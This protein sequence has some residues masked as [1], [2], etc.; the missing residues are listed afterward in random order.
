[1]NGSFSR[2]TVILMAAILAQ[3][4]TVARASQVQ[5]LVRIKGHE[6]NVLMGLGIVIGLNGT[7][8]NGR[9]SLSVARPYAEL[10]KSQG[11]AVMS[12]EELERA[13]SYAI[14][15]V[16]MEVPATGVRE[17]DRLDIFVETLYNAESLEGGRLVF[18][19]LS[20]GFPGAREQMPFASATGSITIDGDNPRAGVVRNGGQMLRDI[21]TQVLDADGSITLV[22]RD[23]FAGYPVAARLAEQINAEF[24]N[25]GYGLIARVEDAKNVRVTLPPAYHDQ[26]ANFIRDLLIV[27]IHPSLI[28]TRARIVVNRDRGI[29]IVT[30]NVEIG[31][32]AITHRNLSITT[33]T[34]QPEPTPEQP[35]AEERRYVAMDTTDQRT[36]QSTRL[37]DLLM[38]FDQ[39]RIPTDDQ[40]AI[41]YE[42][43]RTG[44]LYAE[45]VSE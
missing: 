41:I 25:L 39:L 3:C 38:A 14:V 12:L 30:G 36:R 23:D 40:I 29:I 28:E 21:R 15:M 1:M 42:L 27:R 22:L 5:D 45:I 6:R 34:P 11:N 4:A 31:P 20:P 19:L 13:D 10:L 43:Q 18:S 24:G 2:V 8:D 17:G 33:I 37:Q 32:V 7:G 44:A 16:T 26:P 9:D 35:V